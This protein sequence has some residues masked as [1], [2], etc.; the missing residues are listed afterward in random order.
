M[1][2]N[3]KMIYNHEKDSFKEAIG[4]TE[5]ETDEL[6]KKLSVITGSFSC[7]MIKLSQITELIDLDLSRKE[8]LYLTTIY[9]KNMSDEAS[10]RFGNKFGFP[11]SSLM[12]DDE[13]GSDK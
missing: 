7:G 2:E 13:H 5:E 3:F 11:P 8:L 9:V 6:S 12:D 10:K 1:D 4:M